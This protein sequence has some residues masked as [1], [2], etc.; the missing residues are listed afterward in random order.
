M[1]NRSPLTL[2]EYLTRT[3]SKGFSIITVLALLAVYET[4][5]VITEE[6]RRNAADVL[7]KDAF[8]WLGPH[9]L[10][11]FHGLLVVL[12]FG[13]FFYYLK[14]SR[15]VLR[16]FLPFLA[17]STIYAVLLSPAILFV[18]R[19][20]L[21]PS[22]AGHALLDIGAGVYEE[23]LFRL[24]I[25]RG[26][27]FILGVDPFVAFFDDGASTRKSFISASS[28][29]ILP[30]LISATTFAAYHHIGPF[31]DPWLW[32]LFLFR[33]IA[34]LFLAQLF[35]LRGL[36]VCV[37]AHAIYDLLIHFAIT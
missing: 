32:P 8:A 30:I 29:L 1:T 4:G 22:A 19:P 23:I 3:R 16:Y 35:F 37:Y 36:A 2:K 31:G 28:S 33:F 5:L 11:I 25:L 27:V 15:S 13:A 24:F 12:F 14:R 18:A 9:G 6:P 34:G 20:Y 7:L 10:Q 26:C 17:E 21:A